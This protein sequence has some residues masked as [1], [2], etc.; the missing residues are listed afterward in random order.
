MVG[1]ILT[2]FTYGIA[3]MQVYRYWDT[4]RDDSRFTRLYILLLWLL[5]TSKVASICQIQYYYTVT[6]YG[7]VQALSST[8]CNCLKYALC[9]TAVITFMVQSFLARR[10]WNFARRVRS[11]RIPRQTIQA[12]GAVTAAVALTQL[13]FGLVST[14]FAWRVRYFIE[15]IN[16]RWLGISW[17]GSAVVCDLLLVCSLST[18]LVMQ[19]NGFKQTDMLINRIILFTVN[20]GLLT[21]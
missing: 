16:Y 11:T 5:D 15:V 3:T 18:I 10:T 19:R 1:V 2:T 9:M 6:N 14:A 20:T 17:L 4:Y 13:A 12:L 21:R 8:T 7:N